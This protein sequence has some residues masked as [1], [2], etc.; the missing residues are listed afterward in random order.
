MLQH[1][2]L[3]EIA[4]L[5]RL[6]EILPEVVRCAGLQRLAVAHHGFDRVGLIGAGKPFRCRLA[7]GDDRNGGFVDGKIGVDVE[8]LPRFGF[9][10]FERGV[11]GVAF[12]PEKFER[13]QEELGAQLPAHHAVPLVDQ[14][15][16]IAV[17]LNP[18][19]VGVAD[20]GF[21]RRP[22]DQR[23]FQFFAAADA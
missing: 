18:L 22:D 8:H 15:G 20:D 4:N 23:L 6:G 13:A 19:G 7:P 16:Q 21:R 11:G 10:F 2:L 12:L 5:K 17:G 3:I 14:H 9:G 1:A